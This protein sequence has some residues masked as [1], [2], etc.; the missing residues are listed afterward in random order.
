LADLSWSWVW[1]YIFAILVQIT[2]AKSAAL[3]GK[4]K[5]IMWSFPYNATFSEI[6]DLEKYEIAEKLESH[7]RPLVIA[8][9]YISK[10]I[11]IVLHSN[12]IYRVPFPRYCHFSITIYETTYDLRHWPWPN[13]GYDGKK[14]RPQ[15]LVVALSCGNGEILRIQTLK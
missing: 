11:H 15:W 2:R 4:T 3:E 14:D 7:L 9:F 12:C 10:W 8:I 6:F 1:C 13:F 5:T